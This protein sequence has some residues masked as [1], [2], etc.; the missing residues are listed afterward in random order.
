VCHLMPVQVVHGTD[1]LPQE[2][3]GLKLIHVQAT[4]RQRTLPAL[5]HTV[6]QSTTCREDTEAAA[7]AAAAAVM[8]AG[9]PVRRLEGATKTLSSA[10]A[11]H[12][13]APFPWPGNP[14]LITPEEAELHA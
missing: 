1:E 9:H 12:L 7:A 3:A 13:T 5:T 14:G 8:T 10:A 11:M 6:R 2:V 4:T